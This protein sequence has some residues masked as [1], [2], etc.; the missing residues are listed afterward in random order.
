MEEES[1]VLWVALQTHYEQQMDVILPEPNHDWTMLW[2]QDF[3][4]IREYN[5]PAHKIC[6]RLRFCEKKHFKSDKIEKTFQTMLP[7]D[8][9]LQHQY[10]AKNYQ[11]Y[12]DLIHDLLQAEKHDELTLR[13]HHQHFVGN[14]LLLEVQHNVKGNEKGNGPKNSQKKF[15]KFKKGK[16][17]AKN[18]K[19]RAK[20][21]VKGK[22]KTFTCHKCGG[23][24]HFTRKYRTPKHLVQLYQKSLK[25]SNNNKRS[26]EAHFNDMTKE[27]STSKTIPL[28]PKMRKKTDNDNIDMENTIVV[29]HSKDV[30][31]DLK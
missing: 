1:H 8:R 24:N 15:G 12:L 9:I 5:H 25:E 23:P 29:Y 14:A 6:A 18:M 28:N 3:K 2:L 7:S 31:G 10:R 4:S 13:N 26:Y 17:N 22:G 20:Y 19:N 27:A 11:T 30:F 16:H 21:Q